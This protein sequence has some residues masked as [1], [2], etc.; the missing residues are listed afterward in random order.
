MSEERMAE[1]VLVNDAQ[2][3]MDQA[4]VAR[5]NTNSERTCKPPSQSFHDDHL[6]I[7]KIAQGRFSSVHT[8][9]NLRCRGPEVVVK[10]LD[11]R[12]DD[13]SAS[14]SR[15]FE[16]KWRSAL[17]E[18]ETL[19]MMSHSK[20]IVNFREAFLEG[21]IAYI[22]MEKCDFTLLHVLESLPE[23]TEASLKGILRGM[24][25]GIA[26]L[27][28]AGIMHGDIQPDNFMCV[29]VKETVTLCDF[30]SADFIR[31]K[32]RLPDDVPLMATP[33][34]SPE[35]LRGCGS[36]ESIDIWSFGVI[37]Y[38]LLFGLFP[39]MADSFHCSAL[40]ESISSGRS[41][42]SFRPPREYFD[43]AEPGASAKAV[44]MVRHLLTRDPRGRPSADDALALSFMRASNVDPE[45]S[46][47]SLRPMLRLA[48]SVGAFGRAFNS[49]CGTTTDV[50]LRAAS[51]QQQKHGRAEEAK[52]L[53]AEV[54]A[55]RITA[56]HDLPGR[57]PAPPDDAALVRDRHAA[58]D[59]DWDDDEDGGADDDE[60]GVS[61]AWTETTEAATEDLRHPGQDG[62]Q[63]EHI[64]AGAGA[65]NVVPEEADVCDVARNPS[66]AT[67]VASPSWSEG[68]I[69][70]DEI[71]GVSEW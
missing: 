15:S 64:F 4:T 39:Y 48:K 9:H 21:N 44:A 14:P 6:L 66:D 16:S 2:H 32:N 23:L 65:G 12:G 8:A 13:T 10:I 60:D 19:K 30:G 22:V 46:R 50:D 26:D 3:A 47:R 18:I 36:D 11:L 49:A 24:L 62:G 38:V 34:T 70:S 55:A 53:L 7:Q 33:F 43:P 35:A 57:A 69:H 59:D 51:R 29:G 54:K 37:A 71:A 68:R 5:S 41:P 58:A 52:R 25:R 28:K 31:H 56:H 17:V 45:L 40:R 42:P 61:D 1:T 67:S 20:H 27:H 63:D